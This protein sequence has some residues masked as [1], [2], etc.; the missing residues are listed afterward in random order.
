M[1]TSVSKRTRA[2]RPGPRSLEALGWLARVG[3]SPPEPVRLVM[4]WTERHT[5]DHVRRLVDAG[6]LTRSPMTRGDGSLLVVTPDGAA[7]GG[8]AELGAPRS[9]APTT[10][11]HAVATAWVAAWCELHGRQWVSERE[12][13]RDPSWDGQVQYKDRGGAQRRVRHRPDLGTTTND[14]RT[15]AIEVE[16]QPKSAQRLRGILGMYGRRID[17]GQLAGLL[18]ITKT[19]A[20]ATTVRTAADAVGLTDGLRLLDLDETIAETR[21]LASRDRTPA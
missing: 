13:R 7:I 16:L 21:T 15:V 18:Y 1:S 2:T 6:Y 8:H 11:A 17:D 12:I 10:W 5:Y 4:G 20:I 3:M 19:P 9:V 14:G